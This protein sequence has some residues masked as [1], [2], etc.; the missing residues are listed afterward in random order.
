VPQ[1]QTVTGPVDTAALGQVL[2][3][4][5]V[6]VLTPDVQQNYPEEWGSEDARVADAVAKLTALAATGV[7]TIV[8]PTVVGL[9]RYIPRIQRVAEQVD[10]NI[11]V[12]TGCY[13]YK[14][15]P[16]FFHHRGPALDAALGTSVPDP[17]VDM[18]VG[19]L[20]QG[21]AGTG[22]RAAFLKC[23]I[24]A[25]GLTTG[26]ERVMRAVARA[27]GRTG[28]P[29]TVH[30]HPGT[31]QGLAVQRVFAEEGVDPRRVV[32]GHSG[33]TTDADHLSELADAGFLLGMDRFG[34]NL[35]TT[36]EARADIVVEMCRRGYAESMVLSQD[37]AC[38]IDWVDPAVMAMLTDWRYTHIHEDVLPYLREHGVTDEQIDAMLVANP[39]R[40]FENTGTY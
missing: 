37:A 21:I 22:V 1:V 12:A 14:D 25:P 9:G 15:V 36:F 19:D 3:H 24:D 30:T 5:H 27:H 28:A 16:F 2:M 33:D 8:D 26:V 35:D 4:E 17:M 18:F 13:T 39:R 32:L 7:R 31:R 34:I 20:E 6:F 11:V 10:L 29:I 23:A 38:Y 40:Y